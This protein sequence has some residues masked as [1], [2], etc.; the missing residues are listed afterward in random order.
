MEKPDFI[1]NFDRP[2]N[3]EIKKINN[4]WY[5]YERINVYDAEAKRS[6]KKSGKMLG[7]ITE[8]GLVPTKA[9]RERNQALKNDVVEFGA[10]NYFFQRTED[11]RNGLKQF[12]PDNWEYIYSISLIRAIYESRFRRLNTHYEDSIL[13][14][15]YPNLNFAPNKISS[16]LKEIGRKRNTIKE[17][18]LSNMGDAERFILFGGHRLLSSASSMDN[19]ELGYDSKRRYKPQINLM[20]LFTMG[21]NTGYPAYYKQFM[22]STPDVVAFKD[23]L[24]DAAACAKD[25]TVI[26]DKGFASSEDFSLLEESG[27]GYVIPLR[28]GNIY[29]KGNIPSSIA[30]YDDVFSFNKRAVQCKMIKHD[31]FNIHIFLDADLVAEELADLTLRTEKKN[32]ISACKK[33]AEELRRKNGKGRLTDEELQKLVPLSMKEIFE[34]KAEIGTITVKTNKVKLT[35]MQVYCILKQRQKIEQFFKTY[36][37]TLDFDASYMSDNYSE[38]AWLFL[39]HLSSIMSIRILE[40][41]DSIGESKNISYKDL[42]ETLIKIKANINGEKDW[43]TVPIKRSVM[44]LCSKLNYDPCSHQFFDDS[45]G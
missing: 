24:G 40:E 2:K 21:E 5:L 16:V 14:Y 20:Y 12:F 4:N 6:K 1:V 45:K 27:L 32:N 10:T 44:N 18:M 43:K 28:R 26:A 41:I 17:F 22:G 42:T 15:V 9:K 25:C 19:A 23:L 29:A 30:G 31:G 34:D 8:Q 33:E 38:E 39:N 7:K 3:T 11:I 36:S 37:T 35:S 13:S